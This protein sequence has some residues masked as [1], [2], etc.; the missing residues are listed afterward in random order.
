[1]RFKNF[2]NE[3]NVANVDYIMKELM[4]FATFNYRINN[5][6][7]LKWVKTTVW[8]YII[9]DSEYLTLIDDDI[10]NN[11]N[12]DKNSIYWDYLSKENFEIIK[13]SFKS[14]REIYMFW[15]KAKKFS[16]I[17]SNLANIF[18]W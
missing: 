2:L 3:A 10:Y 1:M 6:F 8:R 5:K 14:N 17:W 4:H 12:L 11:L 13:K 7:I 9:N 15:L 18:I 16:D